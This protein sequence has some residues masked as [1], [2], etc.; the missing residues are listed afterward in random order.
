MRSLSV[1]RL[2]SLG[3]FHS[4]RSAICNGRLASA[5]IDGARPRTAYNSCSL[6]AYRMDDKYFV[7]DF[8]IKMS[9]LLIIELKTEATGKY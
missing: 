7:A 4:A 8:H 3:V 1:G 6:F 9:L 2:S 5:E